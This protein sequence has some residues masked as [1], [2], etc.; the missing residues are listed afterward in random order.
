MP[1]DRFSSVRKQQGRVH[2][3]SDSNELYV[4][5][6]RLLTF[7]DRSVS[8]GLQWAGFEPKRRRP[9]WRRIPPFR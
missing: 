9:W 3:D 5:L 2:L 6:R 7:I 8:A 1:W 4:L